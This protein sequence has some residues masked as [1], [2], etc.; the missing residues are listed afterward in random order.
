M[1]FNIFVD[2]INFIIYYS[3]KKKIVNNSDI[4]LS[5]YLKGFLEV[6]RVD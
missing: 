4:F 1:L 3:I 6:Y 5:I 2:Y